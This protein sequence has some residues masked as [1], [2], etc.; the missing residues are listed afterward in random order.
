MYRVETREARSRKSYME[1]K[2]ALARCLE[3][4]GESVQGLL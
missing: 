4:S 3:A 2:V 1:V